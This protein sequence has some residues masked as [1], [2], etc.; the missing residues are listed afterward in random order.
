V[1]LAAVAPRTLADT[2]HPRTTAE[3]AGSVTPEN[4][5]Y[6]PYDL[7]RYGADPTGATV[8]D[9]AMASA[10]TVCGASGGTIR[11]PAGHYTFASQINLANKRSIL[12]TGDAAATG[13]AQPAT[14]FT[15]VGGDDRVFINLNSAVGCQLRGLQISHRDPHYTGTYVKCSNSGTNDPSFC[16]LID[17]VLGSN[18]GHGNLHLDLDKCID[19]TAERCHFSYGNPSVRGQMPQGRGYSNVIRFRDCEWNACH[20]PPVQDGG[21]AWT[22]TACTFEGLLSGGAGALYTS[23]DTF[24]NALTITG[25]WFG[26]ARAPGKWL[27]IFG[28]GIHISGNYI[29]GNTAGAIGIAL[30][31]CVGVQI[32]GNLFDQLLAGVDFSAGPCRDIVVQGNVANLVKTGFSNTDNIPTGSLVWGPNYGLGAPGNRHQKVASDGYEADAGSGILRQWGA[33]PLREGAARQTI[34]FPLKFPTQCYSVVATL[35]SP[36]GVAYVSRIDAA[37]F[38]TA[39]QGTIGAATL[40]WQAIGI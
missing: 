3:E 24:F 2:R 27:D 10:I 28:N 31:G 17:C 35:S 6:E 7:R 23:P 32:A 9:R 36:P 14:R 13:G 39:V 37:S 16:A 21:Q 12:V 19:F 1:A 5:Y 29:S 4:D 8:S 20:A 25:C 11:A 40:Y 38:E 22:F 34:A 26:D 33:A 30:R 18:A 15:Y